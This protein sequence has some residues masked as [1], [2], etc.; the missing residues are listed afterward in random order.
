M[1]KM[2]DAD[3]SAKVSGMAGWSVKDGKLTLT[4]EARGA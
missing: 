3:V 4:T 2:D 1:K